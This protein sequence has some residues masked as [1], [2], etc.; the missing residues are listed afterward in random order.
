MIDEKYP[1]AEEEAVS[2]QSE[3]ESL[4]DSDSL[5]DFVESN[6]EDMPAKKDSLDTEMGDAIDNGDERSI[7]ASVY[8]MDEN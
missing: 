2:E 8:D 7:S 4:C 5:H 3:E 6:E 1:R